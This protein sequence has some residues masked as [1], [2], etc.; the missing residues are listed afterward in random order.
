MKDHLKDADVAILNKVKLREEQLIHAPSLK[1]I[2]ITATGFDNV[3]V[4]TAALINISVDFYYIGNVN[5]DRTPYSSIVIYEPVE[6]NDPLGINEAV[7]LTAR[8]KRALS[9]FGEAR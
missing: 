4:D 9:A 8:D 6:E 1:L 3:D 2:C 7:K 5:Y